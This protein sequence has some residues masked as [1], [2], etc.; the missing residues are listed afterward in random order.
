MHIREDRR[1]RTL[2]EVGSQIKRWQKEL[3][4]DW[5]ENDI[6]EVL[7]YLNSRYYSY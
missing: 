6:D 5:N 2:G 7:Q 3:R 1:A 4:L